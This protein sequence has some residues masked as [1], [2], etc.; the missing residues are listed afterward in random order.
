MTRDDFLK[1]YTARSGWS[2]DSL[3]K[4]FEPLECQCGDKTCEGWAMVSKDPWSVKAHNELYAP[5]D[6]TP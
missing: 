6:K 4:H 1:Q 5:K 3:L 2:E